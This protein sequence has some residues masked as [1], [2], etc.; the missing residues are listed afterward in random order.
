MEGQR[1]V[2]CCRFAVFA[3]LNLVLCNCG[4]ASKTTMLPCS[5]EGATRFCFCNRGNT[6]GEQICQSGYW[7]SCICD[8]SVDAGPGG[9]TGDSSI[10]PTTGG[11]FSVDTNSITGT[12]GTDVFDAQYDGGSVD[13]SRIE[14]SVVDVVDTIDT[15]NAKDAID[16][17]DARNASDTGDTRNASDAGDTGNA[18]DASSAGDEIPPYG[19]CFDTDE[20]AGDDAVC[21]RAGAEATVDTATP[22]FCT[23]ECRSDRQCPESTD[24]RAEP[25]CGPYSSHCVLDC[26]SRDC[27]TDM[28]CDDL[29]G[30]NA[31]NYPES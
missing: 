16:A 24:G 28:V 10:T 29:T 4:E 6:S 9:G 17:S 13:A 26:D 3:V 1:I 22:G 20:C 11:D 14:G 2:E 21:Y 5:S 19:K 18:G 7:S 12:G 15:G 23:I 27:P 30:V 31:C 25:I 8:R